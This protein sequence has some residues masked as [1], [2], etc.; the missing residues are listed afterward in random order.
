MYNKLVE[1]K[2]EVYIFDHHLTGK[3]TLGELPNYYYDTSKCG[4]EIWYDVLTEGKRKLKIKLIKMQS[5]ANKFIF[6]KL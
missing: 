5:K 4:C 1:L 6:M 2:K 3:E